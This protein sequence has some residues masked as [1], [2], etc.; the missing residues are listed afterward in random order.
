MICDSLFFGGASRD[1]STTFRDTLSSHADVLLQSTSSKYNMGSLNSYLPCQSPLIEGIPRSGSDSGEPM[2][3]ISPAIRTGCQAVLKV[4]FGR[5]E[6]VHG[7]HQNTLSQSDM[8]AAV[9]S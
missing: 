9:C 3:N 8:S 4:P 1:R 2:I 7:M 5:F 6:R